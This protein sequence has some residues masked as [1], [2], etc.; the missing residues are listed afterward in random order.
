MAALFQV[1]DTPKG[2]HLSGLQNFGRGKGNTTEKSTQWS[3]KRAGVGDLCQCYCYA[4]HLLI[5]PS[6]QPKQTL[7]IVF[8]F[9]ML[10]VLTIGVKVAL[11]DHL[12]GLESPISG[13]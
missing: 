8:S 10:N 9:A 7:D 12:G 3:A 5:N 1:Q 2:D 11:D 13:L 4:P 6:C